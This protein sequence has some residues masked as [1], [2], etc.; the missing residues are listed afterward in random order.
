MQIDNRR[1][2]LSAKDAKRLRIGPALTRENFA[3]AALLAIFQ[4]Q[5]AEMLG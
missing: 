4:N 5:I 1:E 3:E 2:K